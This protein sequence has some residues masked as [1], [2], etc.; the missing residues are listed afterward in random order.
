[1][2]EIGEMPLEAQAK[3]L[4]VLEDGEIDRL[5]G[6]KPVAV[7]VR[8]IA[9]TNR[10]LPAAIGEGRF[11]SDLFYR[12]RVFPIVIPPLRERPEDIP[13]LARHFLEQYR[14]KL[15]RAHLEFDRAVLERLAGYSWPGNVR[16]L[17]NVIERAVILARTHLVQIDDRFLNPSIGAVADGGGLRLQAA[18]TG[19]LEDIER[20]HIVRVL[21][22]AQ[23]VIHG[24]RGA[25]VQL[26]MNPSTLRSRLKKLGVTRPRHV[27]A[28]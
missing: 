22:Q 7:D 10:D 11:R 24:P 4:R 20:R 18:S 16:E 15:K 28:V 17:E 9:A 1:M 23:W 5:G 6:T 27:A 12:L 13:L 19:T 2:D 21:E 8:I 3:L 25:A 26:G 14:E